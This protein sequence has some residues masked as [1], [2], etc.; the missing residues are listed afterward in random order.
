MNIVLARIDER[1]IHGQVMTRWIKG[2]FVKRILVI[3]NKIA[4]DDFYIQVLKMTVAAG[5]ELE[6]L[7]A[8][9]AAK[10]INENTDDVNTLLLF[11]EIAP[12]KE[13]ADAG[14]MVETLDIGNVGSS[15]IRKA[16]TKQVFMSD[17]EVEIA[18][19]L[20]SRGMKIVIQMLP[21]DAEVDLIGLL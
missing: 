17:E 20:N 7:S 3:D 16:I 9:D 13:M 1:L 18:K 12:V 14:Y 19:E 21:S 4:K 6:C 10:L 8:A 2:L 11:K 15:R 5:I